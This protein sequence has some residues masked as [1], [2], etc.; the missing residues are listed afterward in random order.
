MYGISHSAQELLIGMQHT[1]SWW[2]LETNASVSETITPLVISALERQAPPPTLIISP[3]LAGLR[4][5]D[6]TFSQLTGF[7]SLGENWN[8]YGEHPIH[9]SA[10]KR[11]VA[12]LDAVCPDAPAPYVVPMSDGGVQI[13]WAAGGFEVEVEV[14][15]TGPAQI[16]IVEPSGREIEMSAPSSRSP[17]WGQLRDWLEQLASAA[18]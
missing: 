9:G 15:P 2:R 4:W 18:D 6:Q 11:A 7:L 8:G 17:A 16:L 13:E 10:V 1:A 12:V 5:F 3:R 14:P